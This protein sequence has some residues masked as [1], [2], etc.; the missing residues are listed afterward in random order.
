MCGYQVHCHEPL[1]KGNLCVLKDSSHKAR[2]VLLT[3]WAAERTIRTM[4]AVVFTAER[5]D[6][7]AILPTRFNDSLFALILGVE[8]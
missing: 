6:D 2:E 8:I 5:T 1:A 4:I 3:Y 7:V